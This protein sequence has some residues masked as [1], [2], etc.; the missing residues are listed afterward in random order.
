MRCSEIR[1]QYEVMT[2]IKSGADVNGTDRDGLTPLIL[3]VVRGHEESTR[4]LLREGASVNASGDGVVTAL[5][6]S[7]NTGNNTCLKILLEAGA[8]VN[9]SDSSNRTPLWVAGKTCRN[10]C[11]DSLIAA[12]A[13][14]N[15]VCKDGWSVLMEASFEGHTKCVEILLVAGANV[16]HARYNGET[17]LTL[18]TT[19][20]QYEIMKM[21]L[22][23]GAHVNTLNPNALQQVFNFCGEADGYLVGKLQFLLYAAG[24]NIRPPEELKLTKKEVSTLMN[25]C[26]LTLRSR[27][28]LLNSK[29]NLFVR[30][31]RLGLPWL[32]NSY[33]LYNVSLDKTDETSS[34]TDSKTKKQ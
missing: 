32:L 7:A 26:R 34:I 3:A 6:F 11:L 22:R 28:I 2:S 16:K 24:E 27:L 9:L 1:K 23:A 14:V 31:P 8:D 4:I 19:T 21:L 33:L 17:A 10:E 15:T 20:C 29:R 25:L 5:F 13:E 18:A 12:G 30:I